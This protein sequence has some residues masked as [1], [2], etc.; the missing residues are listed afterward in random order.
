[1]KKYIFLCALVIGF[2]GNVQAGYEKAGDTAYVCTKR[3]P[4][5]VYVHV[6]SGGRDKVEFMRYCDT[7][8]FGYYDKGQIE[9]I[10]E[11]S[12]VKNSSNCN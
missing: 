12:V 2:C 11:E 5:Q 1:M 10:P 9:W 4:C 6:K 7:S 3:G 8:F